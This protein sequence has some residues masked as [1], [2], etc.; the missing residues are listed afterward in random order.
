MT[1]KE[2]WV[3]YIL[4]ERF[5]KVLWISE[6]QSV[7]PYQVAI[8]KQTLC[9]SVFSVPPWLAL[10]GAAKIEKPQKKGPPIRAALI[11]NVQ[12]VIS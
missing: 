11:Q 4:K 3:G 2:C 5:C 6:D 1:K 12:V 10:F 9:L 7:R 8:L